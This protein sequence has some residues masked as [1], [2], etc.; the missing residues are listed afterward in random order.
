MIVVKRN[1]I[2]L[3]EVECYE[4]KSVICYQASEVDACKHITCPVCK[5]EIPIW[6]RYPVETEVDDVRTD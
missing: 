5:V 6:R 1:P 4:C 2:P 3:Y